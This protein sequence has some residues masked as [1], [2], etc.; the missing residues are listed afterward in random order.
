MPSG[1][2]RRTA[3]HHPAQKRRFATAAHP[4]SGDLHQIRL[5]ERP[6]ALRTRQNRLCWG[7]LRHRL[8][9]L[10]GTIAASLTQAS[11][12]AKRQFLLGFERIIGIGPPRWKTQRFLYE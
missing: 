2:R 7:L 11:S 9:L 8:R 4:V 1:S 3:R 12:R 6:F 5:R 10:G